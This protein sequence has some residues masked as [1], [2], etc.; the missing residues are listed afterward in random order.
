M[1]QKKYLKKYRSLVTSYIHQIVSRLVLLILI[2]R[3]DL[4]L[5]IDDIYV[6][7]ID[8]LITVFNFCENIPKYQGF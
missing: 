1:R 5:T 7:Y 2:S 6:I 8:R 3:G 4:F